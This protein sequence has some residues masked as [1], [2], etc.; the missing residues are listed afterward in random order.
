[1][2]AKVVCISVI[3][4]ADTSAQLNNRNTDFNNFRN[5]YPNRE[6][7]LLNPL[8]SYTSQLGLPNNWNS[9]PL[10]FGP[11]T[12]SRQDNSYGA[13]TITETSDW[14][15]ITGLDQ[16]ESGTVVSLAVDTSGSLV[17][18]D[19][20]D[21]YDNFISDC[22]NAGFVLVVNTTFSNERWILP[23]NISVPPNTSIS[24]SPS[25]IL[26]NGDGATLSWTS[27]GDI[28][29]ITVTGQSNPDLSGSAS[30]NPQNSTT[31]EVIATGPAGLSSDTVTLTVVGPPTIT[32]SASPNPQTSGNDGIPNYDSTI[33]WSGT[34]D[35]AVTS[36]TITSTGGYSH[37]VSNPANSG[38]YTVT[39]LP[40]STGSGAERTYTVT[41]CHSLACASDTV[42]IEVTNDNTPS[43]SWITEFTALDPDT[44]YARKIGDLAGV[45]MVT[46]VESSNSGVFFSAS[47][48]GS[49]ANPQYFSNGDSI[50]IKMF[51][52]PFN[53]DISGLPANQTFGKPNPKT[54]S[55]TV[56]SLSPFDVIFS[57]RPPNIGETF[58]YNGN[59]GA[60]PAPDIDLRAGD[61]EPP[62]YT[63]TETAEMDDIDVDVE[64][65]GDD[66][67]IQI[68]INNEDWTYIGEI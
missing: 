16:A 1:M 43:N 24:V 53:T 62:A 30:V 20:Q 60:Y 57:T 65:R 5:T 38:N 58:D 54:V 6:I 45:D 63:V 37:S 25:T 44:E 18:S 10:A 33:S 47:A 26:R 13:P 34:S 22:N 21:S 41:K 64:V 27:A 2:A 15:T 23:H 49:Y 42:T 39:N 28:T 29:D 3:D 31:Y 51:T 66:P 55:V 40:Q 14:F 19:V 17:L 67:E 56:G 7:W 12:V 9:D 11:I 36:V 52:L 48:N 61:P 59:S 8:P 68:K 4:E 46:K 32:A 50:Y 35:L